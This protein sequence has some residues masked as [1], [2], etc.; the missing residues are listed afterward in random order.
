MN[1]VLNTILCSSFI[2]LAS[3]AIADTYEIDASHTTVGFKVRHMAISS[4]PGR[5]KD[6]SGTFTYDPAN[7]AASSATVELKPQSIDTDNQK[8]DDHLRGPDFLEVSKHA[9]MR[10]VT[11]KVTP[12]GKD[13]F[14]ALGE[15]TLR[16]VTKPVTLSVTYQ[17]AAKD[18]WGNER[19][20]F[21]ATAKINRKDFGLTWNKLLDTGGLVVGE[22]V[23]ILIEVEGIKKSA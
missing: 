19:A 23:T 13:S 18:P 22:D 2:L 8:R 7:V 15:L 20:A 3:S 16:G 12:T 10:F 21:S 11:K 17:G 5:I 9:E 14:D 6:F 4:V 1:R